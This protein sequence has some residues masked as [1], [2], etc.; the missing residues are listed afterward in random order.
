MATLTTE[1]Q[2]LANNYVGNFGGV[3]AYI[4]LY[5]RYSDRD[6]AN[7][8]SYVIYRSALYASAEYIYSGS[9]TSKSISGTGISYRSDDAS[10]TYHAGETTL[11]ELGNWV[12]HNNDG[13]MS[14][15]A[16]TSWNS[17]WGMSGSASFSADLPTIP[18]ASTPSCNDTNIESAATIN[19]NRLSNSFNYKLEYQT[20]FQTSKTTIATGLQ[21]DSY[22]WALPSSWYASIPNAQSTNVTLYETTYNGSSQIG[23]IKTCTFKASVPATYKPTISTPT[24]DVDSLTADLTGSTSSIILGYTTLTIG[25]TA[26][27]YKSSTFKKWI[28]TTGGGITTEN[29]T[30]PLQKVYNPTTASVFNLVAYDSRNYASDVKQLTPTVISYTKP[31][32]TGKLDRTYKT[33]NDA[34]LTASGYYKSGK[35][36]NNANAKENSLSIV[37]KWHLL[38]DT[39]WTDGG[40]LTDSDLTLDTENMKWSITKKSLGTKFDYKN[41]YEFQFTLTDK[42]TTPESATIPLIKGMPILSL[43]DDHVECNGALCLESGNEVLDYDVVD[44]W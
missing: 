43:Y 38:G 33:T 31:S 28:I 29:T 9:P 21:V 11:Y 10:A 7:N 42:V 39:T 44:T 8:R 26:T 18:R 19:L 24:T 36:G 22:S 4:R 30:N 17:N 20:D 1:Y 3:N 13:S 27:I 6:I 41:N 5:S 40:V 37:W 14:V 2:L 32:I 25:A 15:S 16:S 12:Y 34:L 35:F 23:D